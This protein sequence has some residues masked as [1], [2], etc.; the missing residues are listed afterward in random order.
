[1]P[2]E[3]IHFQFVMNQGPAYVPAFANKREQYMKRFSILAVAA[4]VM[5]VGLT[6]YGQN[7]KITQKTT[8]SG[9]SFSSTVYVKGSRKRTE[10]S[11][12]MGMG[13]DVADIEQCDLKRTVKVSD[14]HRMYFVEPFAADETTPSKPAPL[15]QSGP[16]NMKGGTITI[17]TNTVDTGEKKQMFGL[18]ARH[19]RST[20]TMQSSPDACS[21][22][23]TQI[24]TDGWYIDL[25]AFS[26][27]MSMPRNPYMQQGQRGCMDRTIVKNTGTGRIGFPISMTQTI[28]SGG[29][30]GMAITQTIETIEFSKAALPDT[31]FDIPAGYTEAKN[32][33]DLYGRP[34][35]A[36]IMRAQ[37]NN[38]DEMESPRPMK[39]PAAKKPGVTRI[40]VLLPTNKTAESLSITNLQLFLASKLSSGKY[41]GFPVASE[42]EAR[43][44][45]CDMIVS[46]EVSKLKQSTASKIGGLFG[47]VTSTD[48]S[49][50]QNFDTQVDYK[51]VSLVS[52]QPVLQNKAAAKFNGSADAA[53][54]NA[55]KMEATAVIAAAK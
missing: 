25:P 45:G 39:G 31:L 37:Q 16:R 11:G 24:E 1:M 34:D 19:V 12:M 28:R 30:D 14:K 22:S 50:A 53:V 6:A 36:A 46:T 21:T 40:G 29:A 47:K 43:A 44:A 41:E 4:I 48:T 52:G 38:A 42:A 17:T 51:L 10:N 5:A 3:S 49:G 8:M 9:Q 23:D 35:M 2:D 26:C 32:A 20:V 33:T 13:G 18:M 27:P 54:E 15:Q 7:Y 55:L